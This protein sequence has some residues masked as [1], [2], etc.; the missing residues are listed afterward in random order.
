MNVI[1]DSDCPGLV[2][3]KSVIFKSRVASGSEKNGPE[4]IVA[5]GAYRTR[6]AQGTGIFNG[7]WVG[8]W[9]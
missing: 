7:K 9:C 4:K 1:R 8:H 5:P 3:Y 6:G 2:V